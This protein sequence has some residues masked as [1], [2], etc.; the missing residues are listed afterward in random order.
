MEVVNIRGLIS[1]GCGVA[2][3]LAIPVAA[4][5]DDGGG[6]AGGSDGGV[7][8]AV[9]TGGAVPDVSVAFAALPARSQATLVNPLRGPDGNLYGLRGSQLVVS[10]DAGATFTP[11]G[12]PFGASQL[13]ATSAALFAATGQ[14]ANPVRRSTDNGLT[15]SPLA[16]PNADATSVQFVATTPTALWVQV[17][18]ASGGVEMYRS[19]NQGDS[20]TKV[21]LPPTAAANWIMTTGGEYLVIHAQ[22]HLYRTSDGASFEDL[23]TVPMLD[24]VSVIAT[25][26]GTVLAYSRAATYAL[27]RRTVSAVA[28][29][30]TPDA[31]GVHVL[32]QRQNGEIARVDISTGAVDSSTDDGVAFTVAVPSATLPSCQVIGFVAFDQVLIGT[33]F[34][35]ARTLG[36]RLPTGASAWMVEEVQGLP[37]AAA[38]KFSD[39]SF[40][41]S[42]EI[43]LAAATSVFISKDGA[44]SWRRGKYVTDVT[45]P[46]RTVAVTPSGSRIF[47]G[48]TLGRGVFLDA[49]G[50]TGQ[51]TAPGPATEDVQQADWATDKLVF[52]TTSNHESTAGSVLEG[53][54]DRIGT[55]KNVNPYATDSNP[56]GDP[57]AGFYGIAACPFVGTFDVV[58]GARRW[59]STNAFD[60]AIEIQYEYGKDRFQVLAPPIASGQALTLSCAPNGTQALLFHDDLLYVGSYLGPKYFHVLPTG[61]SGHVLSA[62]FAPDNRLWV[63]TD[64]GVFR[65][66]EPVD[67]H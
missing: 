19:T 21:T 42:G 35:G 66:L 10:T 58:I 16:V 8:G 39:V 52:V 12:T 47:I 51:A 33:C 50:D 26:A 59:T 57:T 3:A 61:I 38:A 53:D 2:V 9:A 24:P 55:W 43:V 41:D 14:V 46:I 20:F 44:A 62:K 5:T 18:L 1:W 48:S 63:I 31:A 64:N 11:R 25:Q 4:C 37:L 23:G 7:D 28:W 45:F 56:S 49:A 54:P 34:D 32:A 67:R 29:D 30:M 40:T 15:F 22:G 6:A 36:I 17:R 60:D 27:Y 65:S 13:V